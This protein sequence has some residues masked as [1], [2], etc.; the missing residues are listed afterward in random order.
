MNE[1]V[2]EYDYQV[3]DM[4]IYLQPIVQGVSYHCE[5]NLFFDPANPEEVERL[6]KISLHAVQSLLN[7]GAFFSRPYDGWVDMVYG[8]DANTMASLWKIKEIVDP[9]NIMNPG[10][11]CFPK[12]S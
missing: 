1:I 4:G 8:R 10:K 7:K 2:G 3:S 5:F 12:K 9:N 11:L 6:K